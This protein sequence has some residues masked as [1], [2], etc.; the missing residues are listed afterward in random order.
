MAG[1][2][3]GQ[4]F[5]ARPSVPVWNPVTLGGS[6]TEAVDE[7]QSAL[8]GIE[9]LASGVDTFNQNQL[10]QLLNSIMPGWSANAGQE[11]KNI[12]SELKGE[13]PTDVSE[14]VQSSDAA[15]ALTGGFGGSGLLGNMTAK[16]LG[17]TSLSL[18]GQGESSLESW[19]GMVDKMFA[20]GQ[21]DVSSMFVNPQTEFTDTMA[22]QEHAF[23]QKWMSNQIGAMP[24]PEATGLW[25]MLSG[26]GKGMTTGGGGGGGM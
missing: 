4:M 15:K 26:M 8:P 1:G 14:A 2:F 10:T 21:F 3:L 19:T 13:I 5:G 23:S 24:N 16:D 12:G 11:S 25:S 20:P 7:N 18:M 9:N 22:N 6:Q 17:L